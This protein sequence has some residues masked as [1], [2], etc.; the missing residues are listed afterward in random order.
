M[1]DLLAERRVAR[2]REGAGQMRLQPMRL[3]DRV[4]RG[5][6]D[7]D[8]RRH[9]ALAAPDTPRRQLVQ[10][11]INHL[12]DHVCRQRLLAG[13]A[14]RVLHQIGRALLPKRRRQRRT[15]SSLLPT[16][17]AIAGGR[18]PAALNNTIPDRHT[19]FCGVLRSRTSFSSRCRSAAGSRMGPILPIAPEAHVHP[20]CEPSVSTGTLGQHGAGVLIGAPLFAPPGHFYSPIVDPNELRADGFLPLHDLA[21]LRGM[22]CDMP[23]MVALFKNLIAHY[24][25]IDFP[26][27]QSPIHRYFFANEVFSYGNTIILA[28]MIRHFRPQRIVEVGS[29]FSSAAILDTIEP[30]LILLGRAAPLSI[31]MTNDSEGCCGPPIPNA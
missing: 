29:G 21:E 5:R 10:G 3:P 22:D 12:L 23:R 6:G 13:R 30:R 9:G 19:T 26:E 16:A 17:A 8:P 15:V 7:L 4:H 1:L 20:R 28:A 14:G 27:Q 11:Q 2:Q 24:P 25:G 31:P 18:K